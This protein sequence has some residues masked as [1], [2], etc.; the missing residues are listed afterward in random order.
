M[1]Y[2]LLP[3]MALWKKGHNRRL[4][5]LLHTVYAYI[6]I[7]I[8]PTTVKK[9][10]QWYLWL[11]REIAGFVLWTVFTFTMKRFLTFLCKR[12]Q[13]QAILRTQTINRLKH[14]GKIKFQKL[15]NCF[16]IWLKSTKHYIIEIQCVSE[17]LTRSSLST[18]QTASWHCSRDKGGKQQRLI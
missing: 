9:V 5:T 10:L 2:P 6:G 7:Y 4:K 16:S 11:H 12:S 1:I 14:A 17:V 13:T 18:A 15:I 3:E 8:I